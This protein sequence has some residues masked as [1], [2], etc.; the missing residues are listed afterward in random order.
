MCIRDRFQNLMASTKSND[1]A[2]CIDWLSFHSLMER[3]RNPR[4]IDIKMC[5]VIFFLSQG[6]LMR[7]DDRMKKNGIL[8][9]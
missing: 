9:P 7:P 2:A 1:H 4:F 5:G 3:F 6:S 8:L